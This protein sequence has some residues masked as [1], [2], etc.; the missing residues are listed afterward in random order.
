M[1]AKS[2]T[3]SKRTGLCLALLAG[4]GLWL[5]LAGPAEAA[6]LSVSAPQEGDLLQRVHKLWAQTLPIIEADMAA[7]REDAWYQ[8]RR[9]PL[10]TAWVMLQAVPEANSGVSPRA[11]DAIGN[12]IPRTLE[13]VDHVYGFPGYSQAKREEERANQGR[14]R[15]LIK[16]IQKKLAAIK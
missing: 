6:G 4:L 3:W 10:F 7:G 1:T 15:Y 12:L 11:R 8:G 2:R 5:A 13:L 16:D 14:T 9:S